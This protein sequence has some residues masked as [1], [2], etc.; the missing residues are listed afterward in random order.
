[1]PKTVQTESVDED[2]LDAREAAAQRARQRVALEWSLLAFVLIIAAALRLAGITW[3][4]PNSNHFFSY[5]PDETVMLLHATS[6]FGGLNVFGGDILPHFYN[7]GTLQLYLVHFVTSIAITYDMVGPLFTRDANINPQNV[8]GL[9]LIARVMTALM[10]IGTVW[11]VWAIARRAW[12]VG[13]AAVA[14][15]ALAVMPLHVQHSHFFTVDV[16]ATFWVALSLYWS[17]RAMLDPLPDAKAPGS[18]SGGDVEATVKPSAGA[19]QGKKGK[20]GKSKSGSERGEAEVP[21]AVSSQFDWLR[22]WILAG[23]FAG[24]AAATKYNAALVVLPILVAGHLH[25][26]ENMRTALIGTVTGL[27][28]FGAGF[29]FGCPGSVLENGKF[30]A[31]LRFE[32]DHVYRHG[33]PEFQH[34]GN[35]LVYIV[36]HNL[37]AGMGWALLVLGLLAMAVAI[38]RALR[39]GERGRPDW[40]L[41]AFSVP[42]LVLV[43]LAQSRYARYE[44]PVLPV[45]ALWI[46]GLAQFGFDQASRRSAGVA[47][48]AERRRWWAWSPYAVAGIALLM[49]LCS[50]INLTAPMSRTDPRDAALAEIP[51]G[52]RA[53]TYGFATIPWFYTP[54]I[55][56]YFTFTRGQWTRFAHR[57]QLT[58]LFYSKDPGFDPAVITAYKPDI[59]LL[60]EYEYAAPLR[61]GDANARAFVALLA[62][63]YERPIVAGPP[64]PGVKLLREDGLPV[65]DL[66]HDMDYTNP[67][68]L[69]FVRKSIAEAAATPSAPTTS[70]IFHFGN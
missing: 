41:L 60:S 52:V 45:L 54:P 15:L 19:A 27:V 38:Y 13:A 37:P 9:Y 32:G 10:G 30:R 43:G 69:I 49:A 62:R 6:Q 33:E 39:L 48:G 57:W 64:T 11:A 5:H 14:S 1:M 55:S 34:T 2:D 50:T 66:P 65:Q 21:R 26:R 35:G 51:G 59:V 23:L 24:F 4:L 47:E 68:T 28:L 3:G 67:V 7:Y 58:H 42:Y 53:N 70:D 63:N 8:A 61:L 36:T 17:M 31:D 40:L 12:G 16:P 20:G 46:G 25:R 22:P 29:L 44:I 18:R 56:P